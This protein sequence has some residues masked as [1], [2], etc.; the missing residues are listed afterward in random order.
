MKKYIYLK[1]AVIFFIKQKA[2]DPG[3]TRPGRAL[4]NEILYCSRGYRI[5]LGTEGE[6]ITFPDT[7]TF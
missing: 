4:L 3:R 2:I 5:M 7:L 6:K 1:S